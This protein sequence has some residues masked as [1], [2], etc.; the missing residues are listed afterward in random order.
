MVREIKIPIIKKKLRLWIF[1][2]QNYTCLEARN[3][4]FPH[5][6]TTSR[7]L[8]ESFVL[9]LLHLVYI[10]KSFLQIA[11]SSRPQLEGIGSR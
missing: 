5:F 8:S 10:T 4:K 2:I 11:S 6:A 3:V 1:I 7:R 9:L